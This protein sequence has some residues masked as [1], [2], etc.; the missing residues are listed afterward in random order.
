[1]ISP[2]DIAPGARAGGGR[3]S[4]VARAILLLPVVVASALLAFAGLAFA[5]CATICASIAGWLL[6]STERLQVRGGLLG[7]NVIHAEDMFH[8]R[9]GKSPCKSGDFTGPGDAA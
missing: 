4:P 3:H 8:G 6:A 5:A 1:M 7:E 9:T 2:G